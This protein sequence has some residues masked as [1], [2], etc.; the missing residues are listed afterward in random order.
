MNDYIDPS[1]VEYDLGV[2]LAALNVPDDCPAVEGFRRRFTPD[3]VRRYVIEAHERQLLEDRVEELEKELR[4]TKGHYRV[5][6]RLIAN[7]HAV[8]SAGEQIKRY[9]CLQ[10][11]RP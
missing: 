6:M 5:I 4:L 3:R 11:A 1:D 8:A 2:I 10:N 9:R 7:P